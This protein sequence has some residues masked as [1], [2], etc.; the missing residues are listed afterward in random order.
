MRKVVWAVA[1]FAWVLGC[2][3][4]RAHCEEALDKLCRCPSQPCE[5]SPALPI[6]EKLRKCEDVVDKS[7]GLNIHICLA[8]EGD[9]YCPLIDAVIADGDDL[10]EVSCDDEC[11]TG[12]RAV[13]TEHQ[14][15][16][17]DIPE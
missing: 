14:H 8:E 13:C 4:D 15:S 17:C 12:L 11:R 10:C 2:N 3:E 5:L 7:I 16:Q 9:K 1:S 6:I